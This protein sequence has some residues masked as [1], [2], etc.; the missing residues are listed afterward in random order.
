[1]AKKD[2]REKKEKK[3]NE[4]GEESEGRVATVIFTLL[5]ILIWLAVFCVLIKLDV[6]GFGSKV[7]RPMLKDV[8]GVNLILPPASDDEILDENNHAYTNLAEA[9]AY[10]KELEAKLAMYEEAGN[11]NLETIGELNS[12]IERLK[13]FEIDQKAFQ[14]EKEKYYQDVVL[15]NGKEMMDSFQ[16]WYENMDKATAE[17]IYRQVMEQKQL[18]E[19]RQEFAA[20]YSSME[21]EDVAKIFPEMTGD[22][23]TVV[24]ILNNMDSRKRGAVLSALAQSDATFAA[25]LTLLLA[26]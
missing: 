5:T 23:D 14:D 8:P 10:I 16:Q 13:T 19:S 25:K 6:G 1:M 18:D 20:V 24:M 17:V 7:L 22:L 4:N 2:K 15:G 3:L 26:P 12:E 9:D 11:A 21:A